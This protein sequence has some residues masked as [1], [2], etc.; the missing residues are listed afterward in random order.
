MIKD[1]APV[2]QEDKVE[3][4][5]NPFVWY[6]LGFEYGNAIYKLLNCFNKQ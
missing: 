5:Q 2:Y 3:L 4:G 1:I 6:P